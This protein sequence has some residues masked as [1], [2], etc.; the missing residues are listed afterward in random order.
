MTHHRSHP[1]RPDLFLTATIAL[2]TL[3][4]G[5]ALARSRRRFELHGRTALVTGGSRGLGLVLARELLRAGAR[6]AICA[7]DP[8]ELSLAQADLQGNGARVLAIP[9]DVT[10]RSQVERMV[11]TVRAELGPVDVLVNNAG[12]IQVGPADEMTPGDYEQA[13]RVHF[14]GPFHTTLAVVPDMRRRRSGRI[15]NIASVGG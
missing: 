11:A 6:V 3:L 9:C 15:V 14:W 13:L 8:D 2:G 1:G 12:T 4:A 7:R 5:R 10:D